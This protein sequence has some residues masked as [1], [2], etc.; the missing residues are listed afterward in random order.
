[1]D[2]SKSNPNTIVKMHLAVSRWSDE[3]RIHV[4]FLEAECNSKINRYNI[5]SGSVSKDNLNI[6][7]SS[8][9]FLSVKYFKNCSSKMCLFHPAFIRKR[10]VVLHILL[11]AL[12]CSNRK[13]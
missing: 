9:D 10:V 1:M 11:T 4:I 3:S 6:P 5:S 12:I 13:N 7:V 8:G 2:L